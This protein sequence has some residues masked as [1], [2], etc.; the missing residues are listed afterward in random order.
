M[1]KIVFNEHNN[2]DSGCNNN[3]VVNGML[4]VLHPIEFAPTKFVPLYSF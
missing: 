2:C 4:L 3:V 1:V